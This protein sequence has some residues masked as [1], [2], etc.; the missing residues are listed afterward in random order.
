[1]NKL[2]KFF[3]WVILGGIVYSFY[4]QG[5]KVEPLLINL[6]MAQSRI[7]RLDKRVK[8]LEYHNKQIIKSVKNNESGII[9]LGNHFN[10]VNAR[11]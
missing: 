2:G 3:L 5:Q 6:K 10:R 4:I 8:L 1:M 9:R 11:K 7:E